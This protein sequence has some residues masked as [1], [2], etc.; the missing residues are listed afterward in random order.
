VDGVVRR[1]RRLVEVLKL[2]M[3]LVRGTECMVVR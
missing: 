1:E 2:D 3:S